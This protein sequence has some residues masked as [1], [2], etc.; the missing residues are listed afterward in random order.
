ML[1]AE[2]GKSR[3]LES[4]AT[5]RLDPVAH[6]EGQLLFKSGRL[7]TEPESVVAGKLRNVVLALHGEGPAS[8]LAVRGTGEALDELVVEILCTGILFKEGRVISPSVVRVFFLGSDV[9]GDR[10]GGTEGST[11][12]GEERAGFV[13]TL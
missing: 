5:A 9:F 10:V 3:L 11:G 12:S 7:V 1:A 6:G 2:I 4:F 13:A 8:A